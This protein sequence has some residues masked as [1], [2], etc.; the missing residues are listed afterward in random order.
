MLLELSTLPGCMC[1]MVTIKNGK[2]LI[3][4]KYSIYFYLRISD[5][6]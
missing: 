3:H 6:K 2:Y 4:G 1:K 5:P